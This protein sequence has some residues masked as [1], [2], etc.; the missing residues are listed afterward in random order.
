MILNHY[1]L[2]L[3]QNWKVQC[4]SIELHKK[5]RNEQ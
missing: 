1:E 5:D 2:Q 4:L 3:N